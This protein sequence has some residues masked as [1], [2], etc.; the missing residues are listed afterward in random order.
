[1]SQVISRG[2]AIIYTSNLSVKLEGHTVLENIDMQVEQGEVVSIIGPN[3]AGKTTLLRLFLGLVV[4]GKGTVEVLG[5]PPRRMKE[6]R[7]KVGYMPQRPEVSPD[8][9]LSVL[10]VVTM[11]MVTSSLIGAPLKYSHRQRACDSLKRVGL[12]EVKDRPFHTLSGGQKQRVFLARAL[13]KNPALLL[14]DEPNAGLDLPTQQRFM[15]LLQE[16]KESQALTVVMVSHDLAALAGY[17]DRL[18][19][20][21]R[22]MHAHGIPSEVLKSPGLGNAYR[23]EVDLFLGQ[24][25]GSG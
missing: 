12:I 18:Y 5:R 3:G 17:S 7:E 20:I 21:N 10:D 2:G 19:C 11:G 24:E 4:Y 6:K 23:C 15:E 22:S 16:L 13:C 1:M 8:V 9:P 25:K 14:L